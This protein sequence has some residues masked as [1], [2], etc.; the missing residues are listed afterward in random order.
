MRQTLIALAV[1]A[2]VAPAVAQAQDYGPN[3]GEE[4]VTPHRMGRS[5]GIMGDVGVSHYNRHLAHE[6]NTGVGY[7]ATVDLSPQ[8]NIG[9]ELGYD[10][11][12]NDLSSKF[13]SDG[14]LVTNEI[15]GDLRVNLVPA[16]Y[17]LPGHLKPF[18]FG[19]AFYHRI[20]T[21]GFTPGIKDNTNAFA[22]PVGAGVE[23]D[24]GKRF[25]VGARY[26][27]NFLFNEIN[28]LGGRSDFWT[29]TVDLGARL[30]R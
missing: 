7:G 4:E 24:V 13:S 15:G 1:A 11:G 22:L 27:Y 2:L 19:G 20:D 9:L 17:S 14:R 5:L 16:T 10:G 21:Q 26:T 12:V 28:Q 25:L 3:Y 23:V 30:Q 29:A 8:R 6:T 18:L